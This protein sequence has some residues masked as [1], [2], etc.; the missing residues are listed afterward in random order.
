M[1]YYWDERFTRHLK[2]ESIK[3]ICEVGAR[4]GNETLMLSDTFKNSQILSFECNPNTVAICKEKL[5]NCPRVKFFDHG[6]GETQQALPFYSFNRSNDGA[7]SFFKRDDYDI[8]QEDTGEILIKRLD[9]VL[10]SENIQHIHLLCMDV[11]GYELNVLKGCGDF[12]KRIDYIIMEQ[13][14]NTEGVKS[15]YIGAPSSSEV[16]AF[17]ASNNFIEVERLIENLTEDNVMYKR[18]DL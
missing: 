6:L 11:Q 5:N 16:N 12:L 13:L 8:T 10:I 7:S 17:M 15:T 2:P 18:V 4:Y 9:S 1:S 14:N 3:V